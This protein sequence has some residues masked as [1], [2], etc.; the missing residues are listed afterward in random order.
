MKKTLVVNFALLLVNFTLLL[1]SFTVLLVN[2]TLLL[3]NSANCMGQIGAMPCS[4]WSM[5][6]GHK[7]KGNPAIKKRG[8]RYLIFALRN[9]FIQKL[10]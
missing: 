10:F 3:V 9:D 1:V 7:Q 2:S 8:F 4:S 5:L 6:R